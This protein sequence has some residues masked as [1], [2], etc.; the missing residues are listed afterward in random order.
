MIEQAPPHSVEMVE[1]HGPANHAR[2]PRIAVMEE[3]A[4]AKAKGSHEAWALFIARHPSDPMVSLAREEQR[5]L[6]LK[7]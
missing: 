6:D 5:K 2:D 4:R 1:P 3:F 7:R